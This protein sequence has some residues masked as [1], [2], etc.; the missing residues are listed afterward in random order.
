VRELASS[1]MTVVMST[2]AWLDYGIPGS[3]YLALVDGAAHTVVGEGSAMKW[4]QVETLIAQAVGDEKLARRHP[5]PTIAP[6]DRRERVDA[7]L[8]A[9][10]I[11]PGHESLFFEPRFEE[12]D[13]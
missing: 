7:A 5:A 6:G 4:S 2:Q 13:S 10:G 12:P 9:A 8:L 11:T 3:P 1:G